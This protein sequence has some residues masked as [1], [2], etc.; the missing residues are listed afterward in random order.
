MKNLL[1]Y[2]ISGF[3]F[4]LSVMIS[5][6]EDIDI[7]V[8]Q[9]KPEGI[10]IINEGNNG[11]STGDIS[12]FDPDSLKIVNNLFLAANGTPA[13]DVVQDMLIHD[14]LGIIV[15]NNSNKVRIVNINTFRLIKDI[16]VTQ[17]RRIA[18]V[19]SAKAYIT[20][21]NGTIQIL[22]LNQLIITG[23]IAMSE[24]YPEGI[25]VID[26]RAYI[27]FSFGFDFSVEPG[28]HNSIAVIDIVSDMVVNSVRVGYNPLEMAYDDDHQRMYVA[29]GGSEYSTPKVHGGIYVYG[30][31]HQKLMDS[32]ITQPGEA[33]PDTLYPSNVWIDGNH[34]Y[35]VNHFAGNITIFNINTKERTGTVLGNFYNVAVDPYHNLIL[36]TTLSMDGKLI[37][38]NSLLDTL[39]E[40]SAGEFPSTI[41]FRY[42]K[43]LSGY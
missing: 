9:L 14:T 32:I 27:C 26:N 5:C 2:R 19:S 21:W 30:I 4:L 10:Y 20:C 23:S 1:I 31:Q 43:D 39:R 29:C 13:G 15:A 42:R 33:G 7:P 36:T 17:P 41:V 37:V 3:I 12:F 6:R 38:Y 34:G 16:T 25:I 8:N 24:N 28:L 22:D 35:F 11:S 18:K 40:C